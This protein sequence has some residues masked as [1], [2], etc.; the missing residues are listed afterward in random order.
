MSV[1]ELKN[2]PG[3]YDVVVYDRVK[4][5]GQK[6]EKISK[7]IKGQRAAE[8]VER[9]LLKLRD[10]GLLVVHAESLNGYAMRWLETRRSEVSRATLASYRRVLTRY[11]AEPAPPALRA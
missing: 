2:R 5:R 6:P 8:K 9:D 3:W 7:R 10:E 11:V 1:T 4:T